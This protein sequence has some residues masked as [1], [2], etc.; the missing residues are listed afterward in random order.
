MK[1]CLIPNDYK[2]KLS[3]RETEVAIKKLKDFF[4]VQLADS[5]NLTR[6]S[7]PLFVLPESGLNDNLNGTEIPVSFLAPHAHISHLEI[8]HSL[9]KWKR[10]ALHRYEF[11]IGEGLYTDMNA[12]RREEQPDNTHSLYVDQWDWEKIVDRSDRSIPFLQAV[13]KQIYDVYRR[14]QQFIIKLYPLLE[15]SM[16]PSEITFI[17]SQELENMYPSSTPEQREAK[18]A[19]KYGAVF[20]HNIGHPLKSGIPHG[21]RSPDYD[22]WSLNGDIIFWNDVLNIPFE[23]SSMGI[24]V[25]K[26]SLTQQLHIASAMDRLELPYHTLID[27]ETLPLTIG[28]GIGQSRLCM[29]C[30]RKA[31]IGEVQVSIWDQHTLEYCQ[32]H[33]VSLL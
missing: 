33:G 13:V 19:E 25:D 12:I 29:F 10:M 7:A 1:H 9:A 24:R 21:D 15:G 4:Q 26:T 3:I 17:D 16:L 31:H 28:G 32:K 20:I 30:L 2:S 14:T 22:D 8:V 27:D 6:V 18:I 5:L 23:V 11:S